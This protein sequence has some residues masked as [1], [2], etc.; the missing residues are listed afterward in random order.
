MW[1]I[2]GKWPTELFAG[3]SFSEEVFGVDLKSSF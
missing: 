3:D 2:A 1:P